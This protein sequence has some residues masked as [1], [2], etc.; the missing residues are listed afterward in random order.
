VVGVC[1]K[2]VMGTTLGDSELPIEASPPTSVSTVASPDEG[3]ESA[4]VVING[5]QLHADAMVRSIVDSAGTSVI[6]YSSVESWLAHHDGDVALALICVSGLTKEAEAQ[7]LE[8]LLSSLGDAAPVVV[9]GDRE[10]PEY[11]AEVVAKGARGYIPTSLS[12]DLA[13]KALFLVRVGGAFIPAS[14]LRASQRLSAA[15]SAS[16]QPNIVTFTERQIAVIQA[17]RV[18]KTNRTIAHELN[19]RESTVKVHVRNVMKKLRATNRTQVAFTANQM[20]KD[21]LLMPKA[22]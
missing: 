3:R 13:V 9:L 19:M 1:K 18:G 20:L 15:P 22:K 2:V 12:L 16:A 21:G 7:Q 5:R 17:I 4:I 6:A 10:T 14:C 11:V 8:L